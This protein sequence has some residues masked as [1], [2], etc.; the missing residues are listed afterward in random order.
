M[1]LLS[2]SMQQSMKTVNGNHLAELPKIVTLP[3]AFSAT[4]QQL[5]QVP[6][7]NI[8]EQVHTDLIKVLDFLILSYKV[9]HCFTE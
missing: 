1:F 7:I 8:K 5:Q 6:A 3:L 9:S 2:R 4:G